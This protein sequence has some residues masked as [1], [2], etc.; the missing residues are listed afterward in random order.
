MKL[1]NLFFIFLLS[2]ISA[3]HYQEPQ[4][5][6]IDSNVSAF[7]YQGEKRIGETPF[8]AKVKRSEINNLYLKRQGYETVKLPVKKVYSRTVPSIAN[9][10]MDILSSK[11]DKDEV[12]AAMTLL[13]SLPLLIGIDVTTFLEGR[14]IEY[15]PNSF[16]VEM[17]PSDLKTV[18]ADFLHKLQIKNFA[19]KLYP[20]M[21]SG[22]REMLS[23]FSELS[24]F[25]LDRLQ[26][27]L[28]ENKDPVSFAQAVTEF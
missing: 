14:W 7:V 1:K 25:S 18:S 27:L 26:N 5:I 6:I 13:P 10:Y 2:S 15:I 23:A 28:K 22:D 3:C 4:M 16:Y 11:E 12:L 17:V 9:A 19:L 21:V 8:A 24:S 20:R